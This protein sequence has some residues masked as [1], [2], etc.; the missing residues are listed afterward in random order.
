M[1]GRVPG[2]KND[3]I[4]LLPSG[5]SKKGVWKCY[6]KSCDDADK[7]SSSY[8]KFVELWNDLFPDVVVA[9]LMTGLCAACQENTTK[10]QHAANLYEEEKSNCVKLHQ[11]HLDQ[12]KAGRECYRKACKL[13]KDNLAS[14]GE[15]FDY[16]KAHNACLSET[17]MHYSFHYAQQVHILSNPM[18]PEP[19]Y[20]KTQRKCKIFGVMSE[21]VPRQINFLIDEA[22]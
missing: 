16:T 11:E 22:V 20:F 10:L 5:E 1:P 19:I 17:T 15:E 8:S 7:N 2:C 21:A 18:K 3:D 6:N 14:L 9:K 12:A 13:A 4:K